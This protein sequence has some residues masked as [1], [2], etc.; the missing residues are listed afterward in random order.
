MPNTSEHLGELQL[1]LSQHG[2]QS[3]LFGEF[4]HGKLCELDWVDALRPSLIPKLLASSWNFEI[5]F[6]NITTRGV[7]TQA[8]QHVSHL[9]PSRDLNDSQPP[10]E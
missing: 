6:R 2:F 1:V 4:A 3:A 7:P 10:N 8:V 9:S 5:L